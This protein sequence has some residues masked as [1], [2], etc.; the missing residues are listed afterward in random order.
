MPL[1]FLINLFNL[2]V[3]IFAYLI[4]ALICCNL[5]LKTVKLKN[6]KY[7]K[8]YGFITR[9]IPKERPKCNY[10]VLDDQSDIC[11]VTD[12][13]CEELGL[14]GPEVTLQLG[15]MHAVENINTVKINGLIVSHH[16]RLVKIDLLQIYNRDQ[17]PSR[18]S[19]YH[20]QKPCKPENTFVQ[21]QTRFLHT[22][23]TSDCHT[24]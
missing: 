16:E 13:V 20:D 21:S 6:T 14:K 19:R 23:K 2:F 8:K 10:A 9:M 12:K 5:T 15:T 18:R 4:H 22:I 7:P 24:H 17:I 3:Y 11:F 1:P